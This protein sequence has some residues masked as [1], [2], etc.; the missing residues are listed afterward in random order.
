MKAEL[1]DAA[2]VAAYARWAPVYD[3]IFGA[4]TGRAIRATMA[5][6]NA[7]PAGRVLEVGVGTGLALPLYR[8]DHR[9]V[10]IDLSPDM[11]RRA[12]QRV[13]DRN[14]WN[15]ER[16]AEMD[17][18]NLAFPDGSFDVAVA[19]FVMTVVPDCPCVLAEMTRVVRP[20]G[21]IV[22]VN[23]FSAEGGPRAAVERWLSRFAASLGWHPEFDKGQMLGRAGMQ[24]LS[25]R[26]L[27]PLGLY[28]LLVFARTPVL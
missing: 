11:L 17:A 28:T 26:S 4:I 21:R 10:G 23:H 27:S 1:D 13:A 6:V 12:E 16:L 15:V 14:L 7:L 3:P 19:M 5:A 2:V 25:E 24:L 22:V 8:P 9:V 18:A 20:G